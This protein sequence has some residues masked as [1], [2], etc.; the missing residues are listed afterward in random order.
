MKKI[1]ELF[2]NKKVIL[3]GILSALLLCGAIVAFLTLGP[4]TDGKIDVVKETTNGEV[5]TKKDDKSDTEQELVENDDV[6]KDDVGE[7]NAENVSDIN[8]PASNTIILD[9]EFYEEESEPADTEQTN[10]QGSNAPSYQDIIKSSDTLKAT[11][12]KLFE[13]GI[14]YGTEVV[15]GG[16]KVG[17]YYYQ[18]FIKKDNSGTIIVKYDMQSNEISK[19][20]EV[21]QLHHTNDIT[22]NSTLRKLVVCHNAPN[23]KQI[24]FVNPDSLTVERTFEIGY[25]IYSIDYNASTNRYVIGLSGGQTFRIL[26]SNFKAVGGVFQPTSRT[27]GYTTQGCASDN[28]YIYFV[29][30]RQN[31]ITVYDWSGNFVTL[32]DLDII[33]SIEPENISVVDGTI[34]IGCTDFSKAIIYQ[35]EKL[36]K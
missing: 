31:V 26:D 15:Q 32:I 11:T 24:S 2:K 33:E 5:A 27:T 35:V 12:Q 3:I 18:A 9:E 34:Y 17:R 16:C 25:N 20:S 6:E 29:L 28:N 1:K 10:S 23:R 8:Q 21:V 14:P 30:Y 13:I 7:A 4:G 36:E 19:I 22:Y